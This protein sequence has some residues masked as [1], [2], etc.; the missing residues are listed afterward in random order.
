M[1]ILRFIGWLFSTIG[2]IIVFGA[3]SG[4]TL[5]GIVYSIDKFTKPA[6]GEINLYIMAGAFS[7]FPLFTGLFVV[8]LWKQFTKEKRNSKKRNTIYLKEEIVKKGF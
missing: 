8:F 3:I 7:F 6:Y 1:F 2:K 4:A 5:L